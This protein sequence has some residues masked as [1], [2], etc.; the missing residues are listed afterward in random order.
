MR[1]IIPLILLLLG[2]VVAAAV[3][4]GPT[5]E[6]GSCIRLGGDLVISADERCAQDGVVIGGDL[7][8]RGTIEGDAVAVGGS[9][10]LEGQVLG[11]VV[12]LIGEVTLQNGAHVGGDVAVLG[13]RLRRAHSTV[14]G[15]NILESRLPLLDEEWGEAQ[16]SP[17]LWAR[18]GI[19]L[20][21]TV[22][23]FGGCLVLAVA[24]RSLWPQRTAAMLGTLR[25]C[26]LPSLGL[27]IASTLL[28]A[29][30]LPLLTLLL[31]AVVIGIPLIPFLYA[32]IGL[33]Y[34]AGLSLSG[35]ALGE[36]MGRSPGRQPSSRW[37]LAA[38]GLA[39][40]VPLA[41]LPS[42]VA[43]ALGVAWALLLS[44]AG[45]GAILLSRVGTEAVPSSGGA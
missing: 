22:L 10:Q 1:W 28:L 45:L 31:A 21:A 39:I 24:L 26:P 27:G 13:G 37:L 11:D 7:I 16:A 5:V 40:L 43:P 18:L 25:R 41:V 44:S 15:G 2:A 6:D 3:W 23:V 34:A 32:L 42:A 33:F 14:V 8:V 17:T 36:T 20:L 19:A 30:F 29:V 12:S 4:I 9:V 38:L 35:L